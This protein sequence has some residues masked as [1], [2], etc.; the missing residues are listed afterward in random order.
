MAKKTNKP[1]FKQQFNNF[2]RIV[3]FVSGWLIGGNFYYG[4]QINKVEQNYLRR[5]NTI[6]T[7]YTKELNSVRNAYY[8]LQ[9]KYDKATR[10][11]G[12]T[13]INPEPR[14]KISARTGDRVQLNLDTAATLDLDIVRVKENGAEVRIQGCPNL[15]FLINTTIRSETADEE[16][17]IYSLL[18]NEPLRMLV[19]RTCCDEDFEKCKEPDCLDCNTISISSINFDVTEQTVL[20]EIE[21]ALVK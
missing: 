3:I 19:S 4:P 13:I 14:F 18:N 7:N 6:E 12:D 15:P 10:T 17:P 9:G 11:N 20:L 16:N 1:T 8:D 5:I 21:N 2:V